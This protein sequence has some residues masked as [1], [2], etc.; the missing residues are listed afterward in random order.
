SAAWGWMDGL[1]E[2]LRGR[3][4]DRWVTL[5]SA[6]RAVDYMEGHGGAQVYGRQLANYYAKQGDKERGVRM[7]AE[8]EGISL[9]GRASG[10]EFAGQL[11]GLEAQGNA[12][13]VR[14]LLK[15]A[16]EAKAPEADRLTVAVSW[17]A[18][19]GDWEMAW[20]AASRLVTAKKKGQ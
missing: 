1:P 10:G 12:V 2:D 11:A 5:P 9:A 6:A 14:R 20:R 15:E 18:A 16:V 19:A 17:Y 7:M 8:V 4:L 13:A 3:V